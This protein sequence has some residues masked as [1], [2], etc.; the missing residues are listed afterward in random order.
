MIEC[1][2]SD[3]RHLYATDAQKSRKIRSWGCQYEVEESIGASAAGSQ[4]DV[5]YRK[6]QL[7]N[8]C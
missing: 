3:N 7:E 2:R 4:I 6:A 5:P 8:S 1:H